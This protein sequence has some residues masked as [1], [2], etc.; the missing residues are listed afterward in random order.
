[1]NPTTTIIGAAALLYGFYSLY[2]RVKNPSRFAKLES[3]KNFCGE[4]LGSTIHLI[5]YTL[6]PLVV[7]A[8]LLLAGL[9]GVN[10]F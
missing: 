7:G 10:L 4:R 3:M 8:A 2:V 9:R 5:S 1:M 6:L